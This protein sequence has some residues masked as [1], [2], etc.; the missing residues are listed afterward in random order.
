LADYV[1]RRDSVPVISPPIKRARAAPNDRAWPRAVFA[2]GGY[3]NVN[4]QVRDPHFSTTNR[5][6]VG[7]DSLMIAV[8]AVV[9]IL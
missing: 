4:N 9:L 8:T 5:G 6:S 2:A 3:A 7:Y 1:V